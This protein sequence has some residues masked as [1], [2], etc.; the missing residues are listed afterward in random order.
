MFPP[1]EVYVR[2][3]LPALRGL[4]AHRLKEM[5]YTQVKIATALSVTQAAVS[6]YLS[7][8]PRKYEEKLTSLGIPRKDVE[9]LVRSISA[10]PLDHVSA[11]ETLMLGWRDFL[12]RG[13][14]CEYHKKK[15]PELADCSICLVIYGQDHVVKDRA[16]LERLEKGVKLIE[17]TPYLRLLAPEVGINVAECVEGAEDLSQVAAVPGRIVKVGSGLKAVSRPVFGSSRHLASILLRI[18]AVHD[19]LRAVMNVKL[20]ENVERASRAL[21]LKHVYTGTE[22]ERV[23]EEEVIRRV[24]EAVLSTPD[25]DL[26][27][28][29]GGIGLEPTTYVFGKDAEEVVKKSIRIARQV[30]MFT[31]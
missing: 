4:L 6:Q 29:R 23:D 8:Q 28:D 25:V 26:V 1:E 9:A 12:S 31:L 5:G 22:N 18:R 30:L 7:V 10:N 2:E 3:F 15:Y 19:R 24:S 20:D 13:Y 17:S 16:V 11:T 27:F 21:G 14:L